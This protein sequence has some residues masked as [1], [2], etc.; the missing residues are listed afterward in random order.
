[1]KLK[2]KRILIKPLKDL[3]LIVYDDLEFKA[4]SLPRIAAV[5]VTIV[6]LVSWVGRAPCGRV[7]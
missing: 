6:V 1:M 2:I 5:V 7:D 3:A 4:M